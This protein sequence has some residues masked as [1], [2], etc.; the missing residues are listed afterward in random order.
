MELAAEA[1][2]FGRAREKLEALIRVTNA[3]AD[4]IAAS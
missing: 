1:L 3:S 4:G 2:D